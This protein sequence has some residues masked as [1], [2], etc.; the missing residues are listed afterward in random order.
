V[1]GDNRDVG[2]IFQQADGQWFWGVSFMLTGRK[3]CGNAPTPDAAKAAFKA[4]Y[5]R[6]ERERGNA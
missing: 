6:W 3:G 2:R 5:E 4:E 1:Y